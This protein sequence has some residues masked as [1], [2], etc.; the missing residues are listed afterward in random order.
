MTI[1]GHVQSLRA[2]VMEMIRAQIEHSFCYSGINGAI[3]GQMRQAVAEAV[4]AERKRI[5]TDS[6]VWI[7]R[8]DHQAELEQVRK[9]AE[10]AI[11]AERERVTCETDWKQVFKETEERHA[12]ELKAGYAAMEA[13]QKAADERW[14]ERMNVVEADA[15]IELE[16]VVHDLRLVQKRKDDLEESAA[17]E[18]ATEKANWKAHLERVKAEQSQITQYEIDV[19]LEDQQDQYREDQRKAVAAAYEEAAKRVGR[20]LYGSAQSWPEILNE[21]V[22]ELRQ[23]AAK[24]Q[25]ADA[26]QAE[27]DWIGGSTKTQAHYAP[28]IDKKAA[29]V[30]PRPQS[31]FNFEVG[32][33]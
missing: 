18:L 20:K 3:E 15:S 31:W 23:L 6:E 11:E 33:Q 22:G 25:K 12:A 24:P 16:N 7:L 32:L 27:A 10:N 1:E 14:Q 13:Q 8:A 21:L 30:G 4:A 9:V 28:P 26:S 19:A 17:L 2:R 29:T 5:L